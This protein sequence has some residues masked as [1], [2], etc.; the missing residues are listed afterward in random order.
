[1]LHTNMLLIIIP[2]T[3]VIAMHVL[4]VIR[5]CQFGINSLTESVQKE[6][7]FERRCLMR[8]VDDMS[9]KSRRCRRCEDA[10]RDSRNNALASMS[11][12]G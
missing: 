7:K 2:F 5:S 8:R 1:M 9:K 6:P 10:R 11:Q 3:A 12:S 4:G